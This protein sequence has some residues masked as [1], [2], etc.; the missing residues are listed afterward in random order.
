MFEYDCMAR[1]L[2]VPGNLVCGAL[3]WTVF[4][5]PPVLLDGLW[6]HNFNLREAVREKLRMVHTEAGGI[7][8]GLYSAIHAVVNC[9]QEMIDRAAARPL[10]SLLSLPRT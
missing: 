9:C 2:F 4:A 3:L 8:N 7:W 1:T 10:L 6:Q 5:R